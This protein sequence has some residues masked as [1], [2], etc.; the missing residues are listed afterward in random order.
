MDYAQLSQLPLT[1]LVIL[2]AY[3][4]IQRINDDHAKQII[5]LTTGFLAK[6]E[7]II[8]PADEDREESRQRWIERDRLLIS[9]LIE[10]Q[11]S[12]VENAKENHSLRS[13]LAPLVLRLQAE[14]RGRDEGNQ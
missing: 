14:F 13:T 1:V 7:E 12:L 3:W 9:T 11:K 2:G 6:Y 8:K 4:V 10:N 5:A